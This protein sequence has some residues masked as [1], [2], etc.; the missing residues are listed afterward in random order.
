MKN[1]TLFFLV[2]CSVQ[3]FSQSA[4]NNT[5]NIRLHA[6]TNVAFYGNFINS[7]NF[8][9]SSLS[10]RFVGNAGQNISGTSVTTFRN[11]T[12]NNSAGITLNQDMNISN[13]LNLTDGPVILNSQ[14]L[15]IISGLPSSLTRTNGYVVSEQTNNSSRL[16]WNITTN[17]GV[18]EFPFGTVAGLYIPF[19]LNLTAGNIG[20]VT[21]ATYPTGIDNTPY[22]STPNAVTT[23][24]DSSGMDN[25]VNTVDRFWQIDKSGPSGTATLT[26]NATLDE[27]GAIQNLKARRW[28]PAT[29]A[30]EAPLP[31]QSNTA[32]SVT[33]PNVTNFSPWTLA[34]NVSPL[35]I[36]L[37]SF[38][39]KANERREVELR[40]TT[41]TEINNDYFTVERSRDLIYFEE[42]LTQNGAGNSNEILHY[43][44]I[45][46]HPY[47]NLSY[48]RLKQ[49]DYDGSFSYSAPV[50]VML[51][52]STTFSVSAYPV[53]ASIDDLH[54][55][56]SGINGPILDFVCKDISGKILHH[57]KHATNGYSSMLYKMPMMDISS[58]IYLI[59]VSDGN[60]EATVKIVIW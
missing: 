31:G 40:W 32:T 19:V 33:V 1:I 5:G 52:G 35:P 47:E 58:G 26:F 30:W 50:S 3:T 37:V 45:D 24:V 53:P 4:F 11:L 22:P 48:Y 21:L 12:I 13:T 9:D 8:I 41:Q 60:E 44:D 17:T 20:N 23:M 28:N 56:I 51:D 38:S 15:T 46:F 36:E 42:V 29:T 18:H 14:L 55:N 54:L 2:A 16:R 6:G 57:I 49:T 39:A 10:T 34:G 59:T 27:V 7:G 43:T 25:S